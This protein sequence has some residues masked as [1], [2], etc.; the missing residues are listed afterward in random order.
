MSV[1]TAG[2]LGI[3]QEVLDTL[4]LIYKQLGKVYRF[5]RVKNLTKKNSVKAHT[6]ELVKLADYV[7]KSFTDEPNKKDLRLLAFIHDMGEILGEFTV[8][9]ED[10]NNESAVTKGK[11]DVYEFAIFR[12]AYIA[13]KK[14]EDSLLEYI[15]QSK[16]FTTAEELYTYAQEYT[17]GYENTKEDLEVFKKFQGKSMNKMIPIYL[18]CLD[19]AEG[20]IFYCA[21]AQDVD[22]TQDTFMERMIAYNLK[23]IYE[24][25]PA[26]LGGDDNLLTVYLKVK[27]IL[28]ASTRQYKYMCRESSYD[29]LSLVFN[30]LY[31][32]MG[33]FYTWGPDGYVY[34]ARDLSSFWNIFTGKY[35]GYK[36]IKDI[37]NEN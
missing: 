5:G 15:E 34:F 37:Y 11:K 4:N 19:R 22:L 20:T 12:G 17:L 10:V 3:S 21:H 14:G 16:Q 31:D 25:A 26:D 6:K 9:H 28:K 27:S 2:K 23:S 18:K 8:A 1:I 30:S 35:K 24:D 7:A 13:A 29:V 33:R 32:N 36:T